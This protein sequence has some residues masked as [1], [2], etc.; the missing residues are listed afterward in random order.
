MGRS[1]LTSRWS[2][3]LGCGLRRRAIRIAM[4]RGARRVSGA[5]GPAGWHALLIFQQL[6]AGCRLSTSEMPVS[7]DSNPKA[8]K[9]VYPPMR[10]RSVMAP[11]TRGER[12]KLCACCTLG[13]RNF[14]DTCSS[15]CVC[16]ECVWAS[17]REGT[18]VAGQQRA[19][20]QGI[21]RCLHQPSR[22]HTAAVSQPEPR[23]AI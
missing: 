4:H 1:L 21:P 6:S 17:Q 16:S 2:W 9:S 12:Q 20:A 15:E 13:N 3:L 23:P 5:R 7:S 22:P 19:P 14:S 10:Q 8:K 18:P 11:S